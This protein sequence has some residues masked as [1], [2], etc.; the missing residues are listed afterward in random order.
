M[1]GAWLDNG[2]LH[3][4]LARPQPEPRVKTIA[5]NRA[6]GANGIKPNGTG[7]KVVESEAEPG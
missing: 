6:A 4:D 2:L 7:R 5:I 1:K 3:I